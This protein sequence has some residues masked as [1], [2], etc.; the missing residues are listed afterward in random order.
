MPNSQR[1]GNIRLSSSVTVS[2]Y[3]VM[4][5]SKD[6]AGLADFIEQRLLGRYVLP[7]ANTCHKNGFL[8]VAAS[9]LL[10]ETLESFYRGWESTHESIKRADIEVACRPE[11][12]KRSPSKSEVA[13]CCFFQRFSRFSALRPE[14]RLFYKDVRCGILHQGET[15]GGWRVIRNGPIFEPDGRVLNAT[16]FLAEVAAAVREYASCLRNADWNSELWANFKHKMNA[17]I[18]HCKPA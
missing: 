11:D 18:K 4:E 13:F 17:T 5:S 12:L 6:R 9:C 16:R 8:M 14:A 7:V 3:W 10:I 15:T 1:L 2:Q